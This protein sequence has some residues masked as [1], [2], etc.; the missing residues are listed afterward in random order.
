VTTFQHPHFVMWEVSEV[1]EEESP[2]F[3]LEHC[4]EIEPLRVR[5]SRHITYVSF[6]KSVHQLGNDVY[7]S[8]LKRNYSHTVPASVHEL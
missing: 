7:N 8:Q 6:T 3:R 2:L 5:Q 1:M 4:D